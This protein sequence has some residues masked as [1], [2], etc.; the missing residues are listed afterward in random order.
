MSYQSLGLRR[1]CAAAV[2]ARRKPAS[3]ATLTCAVCHTPPILAVRS[4]TSKSTD[5]YRVPPEVGRAECITVVEFDCRTGSNCVE[6]CQELELDHDA[7][8]RAIGSPPPHSFAVRLELRVSQRKLEATRVHCTGS[9]LQVDL[10]VDVSGPGVSELAPA[11][12]KLW[13]EATEDDKLWLT[14][15]VM[16]DAYQSPFCGRSCGPCSF[17]RI[18]HSGPPEDVQQPPRL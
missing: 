9:D 5:A 11:T 13:D 18:S 4:R 14:V 12:E 6:V 1:E 17:W 3:P 16:Y 7:G 8:L 10:N 15:I 2:F